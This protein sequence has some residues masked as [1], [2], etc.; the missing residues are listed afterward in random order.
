VIKQTCRSLGFVAI[1][2]SAAH[3]DAPRPDFHPDGS[4][5]IG[6]ETFPTMEAY[7]HSQTFLDNGARCGTTSTPPAAVIFAATDC[8]MTRTNI[9]AMYNPDKT[10][11]IQVVV[12]EIKKTDGTGAL[13][14]ALVKSQIDVLNEDYNAIAGTKGAMGTNGKIKFVLARFDPQG[15]PTNGI[16]VVTNNTFFAD[17]GSGGNNPM[18]T[19]LHWDTKKYLNIYTNDAAGLLGYA[20]FPQESAGTDQDGVVV[21]YSAFGR[22][23]PGAAPY[24]LGRSATHEIGHYLGLFHTF[25]GGCGTAAQPYTSADLI[26]D[27]TPE[28]AASFGCTVATSCTGAGPNPIEN[29]MD[30]SDDACMTKF[31]VEQTNR[32]RC[33]LMSFRTV[34]TEPTA[35]FTFTANMQDVTFMGTGTDAESQPAAMHYLWDF[36]DGQTA[37]MQNPTHHYDQ[38]GV[39]N[40]KLEVVDEGS[41][42]ATVTQMVTVAGEPPHPDAGTGGGGGDD[43]TSPGSKGGGCCDAR[44]G[45]SFLLC[46]LPVALFLL[47]RRRR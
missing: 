13:P 37:T 8:S 28:K 41:A 6:T 30:Y 1:L 3:A 39:Y 47:R 35:A 45:S 25:Q 31:T 21:L 11:V 44:G 17:P 15:N 36:G 19:A 23:A 32:I 20:T 26:K 38:G 46:G 27:T 18:K 2:T 7:F 22:N 5:V 40:V 42:S 16:D 29:Y 24:D 14:E 34:N 9:N 33:S 10:F 43:D 12:H 4:V